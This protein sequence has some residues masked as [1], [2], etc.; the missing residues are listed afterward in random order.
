MHKKKALLIITGTSLFI[1]LFFACKHQVL[2]PV[3]SNKNGGD[4]TGNGNGGGNNDSLVC[5]EEQILPL[6]Q[7]NCAKSGC[8]DAASHQEGYVLDSYSH[9]VAKGITPGN[10]KNSKIY[11]VIKSSGDEDI[12]P[13]P[14][15]KPLTNEQINLIAQ[16]INEGAQNTTHC[17]IGCDTSL[18]TYS[19]AVQPVLESHCTGCHNN[20]TQNGGVN[21][22]TYNGVQTVAL[23]GK[24]AGSINWSQGY[25]AMPQGGQKLSDCNIDQIIK[26]INAGSPNN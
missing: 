2:N 1:L 13:P 9:I 26:W 3:G 22:S 8:H 18:F 19:G 17:S 21:L 23:N 24:L 12:M 4:T 15:D 14:P 6:F 10:A 25:V 20:N 16:W 11:Q 5:F 7:S